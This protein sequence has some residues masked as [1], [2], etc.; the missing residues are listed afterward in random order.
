[1]PRQLKQPTRSLRPLSTCANNKNRR[2][3]KV[4]SMTIKCQILTL[5]TNTR[6]LA[7]SL[8]HYLQVGISRQKNVKDG[9]ITSNTGC[10][11]TKNRHRMRWFGSRMNQS[12]Q[13]VPLFVPG[14]TSLPVRML[15]LQ[16]QDASTFT[17]SEWVLSTDAGH[18]WLALVLRTP[19]AEVS[20]F[21]AG[22]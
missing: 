15:A 14:W 12:V 10:V 16:K 5:L 21:R 11:A 13:D 17:G 18:G 1:M 3:A 20:C 9:D 7:L 2:S 4:A 6:S 8:Q 19:G 22:R